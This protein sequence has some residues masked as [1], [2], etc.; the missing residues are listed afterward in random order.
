MK[1]KKKSTPLPV[2]NNGKLSE[3]NVTDSLTKLS[4]LMENPSLMSIETDVLFNQQPYLKLWFFDQFQRMDP[5][6][7]DALCEFIIVCYRTVETYNN[8]NVGD[9]RQTDLMETKNHY[10]EFFANGKGAFD[11]KL[12]EKFPESKVLEYAIE[13]LADP[14]YAIQGHDEVVTSILSAGHVIC[15]QVN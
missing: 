4:E 10:L 5:R 1:N 13:V 8:G 11:L 3:E 7:A 9:I 6:H 15:Q 2:L 14:N 12:H